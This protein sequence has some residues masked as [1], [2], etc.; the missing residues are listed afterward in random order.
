[1]HQ[2]PRRLPCAPVSCNK[3]SVKK[4]MQIISTFSIV[5]YDVATK[6][7]GVAVQSK[8]LAAGSAVPWAKAAVGAVATQALSNPRYGPLGLAM[9]DQ[10]L[11]A[12]EVVAGL[13]GGDPGRALRQTGVIDRSGR[14]AAF[15]GADCLPWAGHVIGEHFCC[16]GNILAGEG[17]LTGMATAFA[18]RAAQPFAERLVSVLEAGQA[19]GGDARGQQSAALLVVRAG[20]GLG[21][22]SDRAVDLRVDDHPTPIGELARLLALHREI[23]GS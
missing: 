18:Q 15:T 6:S 19:A 1:M 11:S 12:D 21:G 10:G 16:Q 7:W 2:K 23:F 14:A 9:L 8:F 22:Y 20:G 3:L 4:A 13:V 5:A 17:V